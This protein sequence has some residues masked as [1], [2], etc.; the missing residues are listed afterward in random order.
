MAHQSESEEAGI[1]YEQSFAATLDVADCFLVSESIRAA[2]SDTGATA[3]LARARWLEHRGRILQRKEYRRVT[4]YP[5]SARFGFGGGRPGAG[6]RAADTPVRIA[7]SRSKFAVF[8][9]DADILALLREGAL[10]ALGGQL[11]F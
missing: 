2:V 11:I 8:A 6:R 10:E 1:G 7:G 9:L 5:A 4:T 3:N